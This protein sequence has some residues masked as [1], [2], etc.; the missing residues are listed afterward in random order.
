MQEESGLSQD[1]GCRSQEK[2]K[3]I[4]RWAAG[5][6]RVPNPGSARNFWL[7]SSSM[8]NPIDWFRIRSAE[9][10]RELALRASKAAIGDQCVVDASLSGARSESVVAVSRKRSSRAMA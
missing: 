8:L 10:G 9:Q 5:V 2:E 1:S 3:G 7:L 6:H 4:E